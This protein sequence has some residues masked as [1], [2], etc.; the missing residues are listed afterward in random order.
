[1]KE[2]GDMGMASANNIQ[3]EELISLLGSEPT[4]QE[5]REETKAK[6]MEGRRLKEN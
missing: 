2:F 4:R 3:L 5:T 1:M 6:V